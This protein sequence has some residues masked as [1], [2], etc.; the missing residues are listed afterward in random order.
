MC[1]RPEPR[2]SKQAMP[3][4]VNRK[5]KVPARRP[6]GSII[7]TMK[8]DNPQSKKWMGVVEAA[9]YEAW[10][11]P[12]LAECGLHVECTFFLARPAGH[13]GTGRNAHLVKDH[14]PARPRVLPDLD[15]L[16]RGTLDAL[17][18]IVWK[19]DQQIVQLTLAKAYAVPGSTQDDG[20]GAVVRVYLAAEQVATDLPLDARRRFLVDRPAVLDP[21]Q[22]PSL[23]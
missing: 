10:T 8:D 13:Y 18:G 17:T 19:D 16:A 20:Q 9:A 11:N 4:Y 2:G 1:G 21:D 23:L 14:A 15:K 6:D 5:A 12:P 7:V 3:V 22:Q